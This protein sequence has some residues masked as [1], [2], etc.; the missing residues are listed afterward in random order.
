MSRQPASRSLLP[1]RR[2]GHRE[3][4]GETA[5]SGVSVLI[6]P[7]CCGPRFAIRPTVVHRSRSSLLG[8]DDLIGQPKL[9]RAD[10]VSGGVLMPD[11]C[12]Q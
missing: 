2:L 4:A 9:T 8:E 12:Q 11:A 6:E 5:N 1:A 10:E 3:L 7:V